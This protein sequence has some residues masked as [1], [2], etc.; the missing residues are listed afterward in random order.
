MPLPVRQ[1]RAIWSQANRVRTVGQRLVK[2]TVLRRTLRRN[3]Y[4]IT[5]TDRVPNILKKGL[6]SGYGPA[7]DTT[8]AGKRFE[9]AGKRPGGVFVSDFPGAS[10]LRMIQTH[11]SRG[12]RHMGDIKLDPTKPISK[13]YSLMKV[14]VKPSRLS[15]DRMFAPI[16]GL[17]SGGWIAGSRRGASRDFVRS[18]VR[19]K[20]I[21]AIPS[22][23][24][25]LTSFKKELS[26]RSGVI[27]TAAGTAI[28]GTL[29]VKNKKTKKIRRVTR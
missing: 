11:M 15:R 16:K 9:I 14:R 19:D 5:P 1:L 20:P 18:Y 23:D 17:S 6:G 3:M 26:I 4:H 13:N 7:L 12:G 27:G 2:R 21:T 22:K 25:R 24:I 10:A 29:H 28:G 8:S